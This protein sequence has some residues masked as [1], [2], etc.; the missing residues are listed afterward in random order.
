MQC[1]LLERKKASDQSSD[2]HVV[3]VMQL[4]RIKLFY[5]LIYDGDARGMFCLDSNA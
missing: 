1:G 3:L 4:Y 2:K 5:F